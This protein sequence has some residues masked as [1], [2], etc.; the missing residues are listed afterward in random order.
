M[1]D[2]RKEITKTFFE[3]EILPEIVE[4]K[5]QIRRDLKKVKK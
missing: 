5:R 3:F 4:S 2:K 1:L